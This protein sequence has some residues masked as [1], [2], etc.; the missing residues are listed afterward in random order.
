MAD[1]CR[2]TDYGPGKASP[3]AHR[4]RC[5]AMD[6]W[7][8]DTEGTFAHIEV[9]LY[10]SQAKNVVGACCIIVLFNVRRNKLNHPIAVG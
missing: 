2:R 6:L 7:I 10:R 5:E 1:P 3:V 8:L 4:D 9:M